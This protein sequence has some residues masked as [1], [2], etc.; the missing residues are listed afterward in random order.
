MGQGSYFCFL[1][2]P[3]EKDA[4]LKQVEGFEVTTPPNYRAHL[5]SVAGKTY[6][7]TRC[8]RVGS[9]THPDQVNTKQ[10]K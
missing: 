6:K 10:L 1:C 8:H 2:D 3:T 4:A 9:N 5:V 7:R